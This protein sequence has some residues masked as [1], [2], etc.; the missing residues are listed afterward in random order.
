MSLALSS[1]WIFSCAVVNRENSE[2]IGQAAME[3][4]DLGLSCLF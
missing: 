3:Q 2:D 4:F 1:P